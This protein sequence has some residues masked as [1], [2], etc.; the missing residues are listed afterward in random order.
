L[1]WAKYQRK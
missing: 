1:Q